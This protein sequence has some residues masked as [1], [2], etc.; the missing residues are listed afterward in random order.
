MRSPLAGAPKS[1]E[2]VLTCLVR[3]LHSHSDHDVDALGRISGISSDLGDKYTLWQQYGGSGT[4]LS[5]D[6]L[7]FL[8]ESRGGSRRIS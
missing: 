7:S 1:Y 3:D 5:F 6:F 2:H 4:P 8:S